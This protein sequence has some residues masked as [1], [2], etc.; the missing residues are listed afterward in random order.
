MEVKNVMETRNDL[1]N[2]LKEVGY[3]IP[4]MSE[5]ILYL[6]N[7]VSEG[8]KYFEKCILFH[9]IFIVIIS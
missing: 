4:K 7:E 8:K 9:R 2:K 6:R 1:K 5:A 3:I